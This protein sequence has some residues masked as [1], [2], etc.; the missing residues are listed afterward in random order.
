MLLDLS[1]MSD[2]GVILCCISVVCV[3]IAAVIYLGKID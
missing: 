3:G 2:T 1:Q